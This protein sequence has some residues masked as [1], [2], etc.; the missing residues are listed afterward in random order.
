MSG[1][2]PNQGRMTAAP[3][4][5]LQGPVRKAVNIVAMGSSRNDFMNAQLMEQRPELFIGAEL[6]TI[7]YMGAVMNCDRIVHVD[8]VHDYT[9]HPVVKEMLDTAAKRNIPFYTSWPHPH[10]P[11]HVLYPFDKVADAL[12]HSYLNGTVAYT[13]ALAMAEGFNEIG[14][15]G[16]DFSYPDAHMSESGRACVEFL[17]GIGTQRGVK[18]AIGANSTLMD[19][20]CNQMPYG[21]FANPLLPPVRGGKLMTVPEIREHCRKW[22]NPVTRPLVYN[23]EVSA[24]AGVQPI[25]AVAPEQPSAQ[26]FTGVPGFPQMMPEHIAQD[27]A[28]AAGLG[29][30]AP[31]QRFAGVSPRISGIGEL[32]IAPLTAA[33][34]QGKPNGELHDE[35]NNIQLPGE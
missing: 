7:N 13:V 21:F 30:G 24:P 14:L 4:V 33:P 8:P 2:H 3:T 1:N 34:P 18:F 5:S 23:V 6:W 10:Y 16:C 19:M 9:G 12:G 11:N 27:H 26:P 29:V 28:R 32:N 35:T 15:F 25:E 20:N 17:M 22:R 31:L